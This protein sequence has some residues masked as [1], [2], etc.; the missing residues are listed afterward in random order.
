MGFGIRVPGVR[1]STSGVRIGPRVANVRVSTRGVSASVGPRALRV[2]ASKSGVRASS[3]VGPFRVSSSGVSAQARLGPASLRLGSGGTSAAI[4]LAPVWISARSSGGH[5]SRM[6]RS[7]QEDSE[8]LQL[9]RSPQQLVHDFPDRRK[10]STEIQ[11][12]SEQR[13]VHGIHSLLLDVAPA[14][15]LF[16]S[17]GLPTPDLDSAPDESE[18]REAAVR[19]FNA[20]AQEYQGSDRTDSEDE[21]EEL[22]KVLIDQRNEAV[23]LVNESLQKFKD[24][25]S[26]AS[27]LCLQLCFADNGGAAAPV[28]LDDGDLLV[29][30]SFPSA[31]DM[32]W[33]ERAINTFGS[34]FKHRSASEVVDQHIQAVKQLVAATIREAFEVH[35]HVQRVRVLVMDWAQSSS[36]IDTRHVA[37]EMQ[38]S[39]N[40][41]PSIQNS[42]LE[43]CNLIL[44]FLSQW[45][46]AHGTGDDSKIM[47]L[48]N[49]WEDGTS[50]TVS[51]LSTRAQSFAEHMVLADHSSLSPHLRPTVSDLLGTSSLHLETIN[52][53]DASDEVFQPIFDETDF[54]G[55]PVF[56]I[57]L[58]LLIRAWNDESI[59]I[60]E[61]RNRAQVLG[62]VLEIG[63]N[64][65]SMNS[66]SLQDEPNSAGFD[67]ELFQAAIALAKS[68]QPITASK[69]QRELKI[70]F[71]RAHRLFDL[72]LEG[73][74][75]IPD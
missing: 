13:S 57:Y 4:S 22:M 33:P 66:L 31:Y 2:T 56:W 58:A 67:D 52:E 50:G 34:E 51:L 47:S 55:G 54:V 43:A 74:H 14:L 32:V 71:A 12:S 40:D 17:F 8:I 65:D 39:R 45:W 5:S 11:M 1:I 59:D 61:L 27:L 28:G 53:D 60:G 23:G 63:K 64:H 15:V 44:D 10:I 24:G 37:I 25:D 3:N 7:S 46:S 42:S 16:G 29:F 9:R 21:I 6:N 62:N 49:R 41:L 70:G 38:A 72:L 36:A 48:V 68:G 75:V 69:L 30:M 26:L 73:G 19:L 20:K 18:I 35:P